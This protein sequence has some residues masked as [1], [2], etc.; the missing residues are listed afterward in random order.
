[1][2]CPAFAAAVHKVNLISH[3][4]MSS[5]SPRN[6]V[7]VTKS[8]R[9]SGNF[10]IARRSLLDY[11]ETFSSIIKERYSL[12]FFVKIVFSSGVPVARLFRVAFTPV[13]QRHSHTCTHVQKEETAALRLISKRPA[14]CRSASNSPFS[15]DRYNFFSVGGTAVIL[16]LSVPGNEQLRWTPSAL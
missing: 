4:N 3:N 13:A 12:I 11:T 7:E 8:T 1:M 2:L 15:S 14:R 5:D 9:T 16:I 6:Y 10:H